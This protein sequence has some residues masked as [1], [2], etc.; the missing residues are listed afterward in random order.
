MKIWKEEGMKIFIKD[1]E[2][3]Q[4]MREGGKILG[5]VLAEIEKMIAPGI[6]TIDLDIKAEE[7]TKKLGG[8]PSFKGYRGFRHTLCTSIN[9]QV[10]HGIPGPV[11]LK[12]GD[13]LTVDCGVLYKGFHTD[14][15]IT[16]G[17]GEIDSQKQKFINTCEKALQRAIEA[18]RPGIR[19]KQLSKIIQE[20]VEKQGYSPIRD[21]VGH[22]VGQKLHE[23]PCI[24]NFVNDEPSPVLQQGMT[25][26]IEPIISMGDYHIKTLRDGWT[27]V[28]VD[29]SLAAQIE[30]TI[31]I[32]EKGAEILTKRPN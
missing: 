9:E 10:V 20:I 6:T 19:V 15:A 25:L 14:S 32:T 26:A 23:D 3:I 4:A 24:Y 30:H 7:L 12:E 13:I 21:M 18:A 1:K 2:E 29:G 11:I 28:T 5:I 16:K 8:I 22:G 17:V 27:T 31:V